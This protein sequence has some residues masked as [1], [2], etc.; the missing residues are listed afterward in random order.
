MLKTFEVVV[1]ILLCFKYSRSFSFE[2]ISPEN[3]NSCQTQEDRSNLVE[4]HNL[5]L[6]QFTTKYV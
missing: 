4:T 6:R 1:L 5:K 2:N 3:V